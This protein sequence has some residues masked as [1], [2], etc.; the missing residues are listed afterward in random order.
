MKNRIMMLAIL[1]LAAFTSKSYAQSNKGCGHQGEGA[2]IMSTLS[3][4]QKTKMEKLKF[5][6][7]KAMLP[8][9]NQIGEKKAHLQTLMTA[10]VA[11][12]EAINKTIDEMGQLKTQAAKMKAA[13]Q[14]EIRKILTPEQRLEFDLKMAKKEQKNCCDENEGCGHNN[15]KGMKMKQ[16]HGCAGEDVKMEIIREEKIVK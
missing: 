4:D 2:C 12:M 13:H 10:D 9:K 6:H 7:R 16:R 11:D 15:G 1:M 3:A 14:Q 8:V 5:D